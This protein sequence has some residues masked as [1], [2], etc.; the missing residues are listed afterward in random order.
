M[1]VLATGRRS[2]VD[3]LLIAGVG[4]LQRV[5]L[6]LL[7]G[8][9]HVIRFSL[10]RSLI[11]GQLRKRVDR[12]E[13]LLPI[14]SRSDDVPGEETAVRIGKR[15]NR[16]FERIGSLQRTAFELCEFVLP[17]ERVEPWQVHRFERAFQNLTGRAGV[18]ACARLPDRSAE[19]GGCC[20][21]PRYEA[22][23]GD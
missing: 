8:A 11:G 6:L 21:L 15:L 10:Q 17:A 18:L 22:A 14:F 4:V 9:H 3:A 5:E 19:C 16:V 13:K 7:I 2:G 12:I 1:V 23:G 20:R